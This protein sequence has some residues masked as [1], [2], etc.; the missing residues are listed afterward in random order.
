MK[1][2]V[3]RASEVIPMKN[4]V[5]SLDVVDVASPCPANWDDMHGDDRVR[6]CDQCQLNVYDLSSMTRDDA[7]RLVNER[8]GRLCVR[9]LRRADR[10]VLTRDCPV[11]VAAWRKRIARMWAGAAAIF[12]AMTLSTLFGR[13]AIAKEPVD[14]KPV[15]DPKELVEIRGDICLTP[16]QQVETLVSL[17][18]HVTRPEVLK[19]LIAAILEREAKL[20]GGMPDPKNPEALSEKL[21]QDLAAKLTDE[22]FQ[23]QPG[24]PEHQALV[25]QL[26]PL[27]TKHPDLTANVFGIV[28]APIGGREPLLILGRLK[29][30]IAPKLEEVI[31]KPLTK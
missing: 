16:T 12:G 27:T 14:P 3:L 8:E 11:G 17:Q 22:K 25:K 10:T 21:R 15:I 4:L 18:I 28:V 31:E 5:S 29:A 9:F 30:P 13:A 20:T 7:L 2:F 24:T 19:K 26:L 1:K 23:P 6:H